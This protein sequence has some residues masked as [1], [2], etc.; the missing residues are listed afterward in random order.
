MKYKPDQKQITW[1]ITVFLAIA[2]GM[3]F[4]YLLFHGGTIL[5]ALQ[6]VLRTISAVLYGVILGYI[7]S[8]VLSFIENKILLPIFNRADV[9]VRARSIRRESG[10]CG[11]ARY[12]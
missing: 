6:T 12:S 11:G 4:Y 9:D 8:P 5:S 1:G 7:L 2:A 10:G 3:V